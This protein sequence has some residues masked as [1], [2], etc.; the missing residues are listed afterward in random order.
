MVGSSRVSEL[1]QG[2]GELKNAEGIRLEENRKPSVL[3]IPE[4]PIFHQLGEF[5]EMFRAARE[6]MSFD[7]IFD[8]GEEVLETDFGLGGI[9]RKAT[10]LAVD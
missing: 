4:V 10:G 6:V 1:G 2:S 5:G 8:F 7:E 3:V 9:I